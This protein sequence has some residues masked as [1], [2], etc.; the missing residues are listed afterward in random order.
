[1]AHGENRLTAPSPA[2]RAPATA[3]HAHG[4]D[5]KHEHGQ[6][7]GQDHGHDH[8]SARA[9]LT[10]NQALVLG[11]LDKAS[12]PVS[13]YAIL[14]ALRA[15]GLRAPLQIYRALD[16]L[17]DAGLA[18][19]LESMNAFVTCRHPGHL[20][21]SSAAFLICERCG[22]VDEAADDALTAP[23]AAIANRGGFSVTRATIELRGLCAACG[24]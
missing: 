10:R 4:H 19:R 18:H 1:M 22:R 20:A 23:I 24:A 6:D 17:I 16:K 9:G 21:V 11:V 12:A 2:G 7:H 14:D 15:E 13:A 5:Q 3:A 8:A